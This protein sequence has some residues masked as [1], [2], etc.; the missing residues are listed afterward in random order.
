MTSDTQATE[1]VEFTKMQRAG[2]WL[3]AKWGDIRD[4]FLQIWFCHH[5]AKVLGDME[6]RMSVVLDQATECLSKPYYDI[7]TMIG[8]ISAYQ[9]KLYSDGYDEGRKDTI[10]EFGIS[11]KDTN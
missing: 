10:E 5:N 8:E 4:Y 7:D 1:K 11:E 9:T 2:W 3:E 6:Y